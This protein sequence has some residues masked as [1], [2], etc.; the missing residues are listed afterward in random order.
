M[1]VCVCERERARERE[2]EIERESRGV[3]GFSGEDLPQRHWARWGHP[4]RIKRRTNG[5]YTL[6]TVPDTRQSVS[7]TQ[8]RVPD[9]HGVCWAHTG[10][11]HTQ[12]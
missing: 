5:S 10:V 9:T 6:G 12:A 3:F 4:K 2:S 1:S 11:G 8:R 7:D